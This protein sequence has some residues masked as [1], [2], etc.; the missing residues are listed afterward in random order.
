MKSGDVSLLE[1]SDLFLVSADNIWRLSS[2]RFYIFINDKKV[3]GDDECN[4]V[5]IVLNGGRVDDPDGF[6]FD[7]APIVYVWG[8]E[9]WSKYCEYFP[10][11]QDEHVM[12]VSAGMFTPEMAKNSQSHIV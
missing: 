1:I 6:F 3:G 2:T 10:N 12:M 4:N 7:F 5:P 8:W 11:I 9:V